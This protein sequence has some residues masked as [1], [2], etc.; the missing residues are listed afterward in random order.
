MPRL[1]KEE[2]LSLFGKPMTPAEPGEEPPFDFWTYFDEIPE[3]DFE[4]HNF[5]EGEV[6]NVYREP[7][8]RFEHVIVKSETHNV[9]MVLILDRQK[10]EVVGHR[11]LDLNEEYGIPPT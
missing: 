7:T 8:G 11:L 5:S 9:L 3:A 4:G 2:Y 6:E 10:L 1:S